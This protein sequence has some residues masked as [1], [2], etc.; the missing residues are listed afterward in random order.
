MAKYTMRKK[1][2]PL[3]ITVAFGLSA[4]AGEQF[5]D[6]NDGLANTGTGVLGDGAATSLLVL[7]G[8]VGLGVV[9]NSDD[10]DDGVVVT[11]AGGGST[12]GDDGSD[13]TDGDTDGADDTDSDTDD[14]TDGSDDTDSDTDDS[15]DGSDDTDSGTD[16]STDGSG[17]T[18]DGTDG[19]DDDNGSS[20]T[21]NPTGDPSTTQVPYLE[22]PD[23]LLGMWRGTDSNGMSQTA[24]AIAQ[25]V[26]IGNTG[27]AIRAYSTIPNVCL[28]LAESSG[29]VFQYTIW[30]PT[31]DGEEII[32]NEKWINNGDGSLLYI[33]SGLRE[34]QFI[35]YKTDASN[36]LTP[37]LWLQGRWEGASADGGATIVADINTGNITV[38]ELGGS[39]TNLFE[40]ADQPQ[41]VVRVNQDDSRNYSV[42][43]ITPSDTVSNTFASTGT[44]TLNYTG[45]AGEASMT[46][47]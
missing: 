9:L 25:D 29:S 1:L 28:H 38:G 8:L 47:Q 40:L 46:R 26:G 18:D 10:D 43:V 2:L 20:G 22:P 6:T 37:P 23:W 30:Y 19:S 31:E 13:D 12:S 17:G 16:D 21:T 39:R 11:T 3:A 5:G 4:C 15:A 32:I 44:N 41:S 33:V 27:T 42:T 34:D 36:Y 7:G 14:S 24:F 45:S 35:M